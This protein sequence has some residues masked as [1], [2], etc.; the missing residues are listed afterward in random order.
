MIFDPRWLCNKAISVK[1]IQ[2]Y[3][4][5]KCLLFHFQVILPCGKKNINPNRYHLL[6]M[7]SMKCH[8]A[9]TF[10]P[11]W[12]TSIDLTAAFPSLSHSSALSSSNIKPCLPL[13]P[14]LHF[15]TV[16]RVMV[17]RL[18][19]SSFHTPTPALASQSYT[20]GAGFLWNNL[21]ASCHH[22]QT[23]EKRKKN[24]LNCYLVCANDQPKHSL[25]LHLCSVFPATAD[26]RVGAS[27]PYLLYDSN[28]SC[29]LL[30]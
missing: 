26:R 17:Q 15:E 11:G 18:K 6:D 9:I 16:R 20:T 23:W 12:Q 14:I 27:L 5:H 28:S 1:W 13:P 22:R 10:L 25:L 19:R 8:T 3:R 2:C 30:S 4:E 21:T 7:E 29:H 24:T